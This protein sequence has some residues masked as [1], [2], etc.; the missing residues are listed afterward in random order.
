MT[1]YC[2]ERHQYY[3][4]LKIYPEGRLK[5]FVKFQFVFFFVIHLMTDYYLNKANKYYNYCIVDTYVC[6]L[7]F[8][9]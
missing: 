3:L 5:L 4:V 6:M 1:H 8:I 7:F 9:P 2:V